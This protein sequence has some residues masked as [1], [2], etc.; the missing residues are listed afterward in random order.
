MNVF[1]VCDYRVC[2]KAGQEH[3]NGNSYF[4]EHVQ[5]EDL[6]P[7]D[8]I[9]YFIDRD[10]IKDII[11]VEEVDEIQV[12]VHF[13]QIFLDGTNTCI[14]NKGFIIDKVIK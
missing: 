2:L 9:K 14:F 13:K 4:Y 12:R 7:K 5:V 1:L 11:K 3:D 8:K 6:K 10:G